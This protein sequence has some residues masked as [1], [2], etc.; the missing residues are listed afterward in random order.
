M[1]GLRKFQLDIPL[2][3]QLVILLHATSQNFAGI[4][5]W[6]CV[7]DRFFIV[8]FVKLIVVFV[9]AF[10]IWPRG[11]KKKTIATFLKR[12][13]RQIEKIFEG[14]WRRLKTRL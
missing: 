7:C 11:G 12:G 1:T 10:A 6:N 13:N 8:A 2:K 9:N 14:L 5:S 4:T 3:F